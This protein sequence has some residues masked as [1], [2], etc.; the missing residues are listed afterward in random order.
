MKKN[1][2]IIIIIASISFFFHILGAFFSLGAH[3]ADEHYQILEFLNYKLGKTDASGLA[4]EFESQIRPWFQIYIYY[5]LVK[6][7]NFFGVF[8]PFH[9]ALFF[10]V[11]SSLLG[12]AAICSFYPLIK[13]WFEKETCGKICKS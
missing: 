5:Y 10:R 12:F 8:S 7:L 11:V 4:W 9:Y 13:R 3:H 6:F 2:K 1:H